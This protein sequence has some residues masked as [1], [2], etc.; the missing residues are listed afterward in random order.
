MPVKILLYS[1]DSDYGIVFGWDLSHFGLVLPSLLQLPASIV[2]GNKH[3]LIWYLKKDALV[4]VM[5]H[6]LEGLS[7]PAS[8]DCRRKLA[9]RFG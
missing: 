9:T 5:S 4:G 2:G 6:P 1:V 3:P 7:S 8:A